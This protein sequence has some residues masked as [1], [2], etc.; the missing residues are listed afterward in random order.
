MKIKIEQLNASIRDIPLPDNMME[1]P[2]SRQ[3]YPVPFFVARPP[4]GQDW[5]FRVVHNE[6]TVRALK[7]RLCW[8][9]GQQMG[10]KK[11]FVTG[12][13]CVVTKTT[14]EPPSH[15]S[16]AR[17]AAIACPF[18]ANPRMRRNEVDM[19][20][21]HIMPPGIAIM[22]NPGVTAVLIT[23]TLKP[24]LVPGSIGRDFLI[25]MGPPSSIEW[26]AHRRRATKDEVLA[27]IESGLV[28]LKE[29]ADGDPEPEEANMELARLLRRTLEWLPKGEVVDG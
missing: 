8:V 28:L 7:E 3:G 19:P 5:D 24:F 21:G 15:L 14:A 20:E 11:A 26:Y 10:I 17:Y 23:D 29:Q 18:L 1:R 13:M 2:V 6:E 12:P 9:C 4:E 16:C 22:R 25:E 27:S